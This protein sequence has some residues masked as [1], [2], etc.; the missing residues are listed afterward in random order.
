MTTATQASAD[1][2]GPAPSGRPPEGGGAQPLGE[3]VVDAGEDDLGLRV[4]EAD[5]VLE[6]PQARRA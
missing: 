4:A 2:A 3:V 5:V 1:T 6:H